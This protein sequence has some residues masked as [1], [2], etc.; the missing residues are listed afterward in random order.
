MNIRRRANV[1]EAIVLQH[2]TSADLI[3]HH[4]RATD[5]KVPDPAI[6]LDLWVRQKRHP[7]Q[8]IAPRLRP[9]RLQ[10]LSIQLKRR[11]RLPQ[12]IE[13]AINHNHRRIRRIRV[14]RAHNRIGR[15]TFRAKARRKEPPRRHLVFMLLRLCKLA[16]VD[17]LVV[18]N[19]DAVDKAIAIKPVRRKVITVL[20]LR[21]PIAIERS[22]ETRRHFAVN[23][24][25]RRRLKPSRRRIL[26]P[27][28]PSWHF[29]RRV[30]KSRPKP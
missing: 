10:R 20:E 26:I 7:R 28:M 17:R 2:A 22:F 6:R 21:R 24:L 9:N 5:T 3:D 8:I 27:R 12:R 18:L 13:L 4:I 15:I 23:Q 1:H 16:R 11:P 19:R 25:H 14:I 30:S 29:R